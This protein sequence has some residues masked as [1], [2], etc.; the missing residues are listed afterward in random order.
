MDSHSLANDIYPVNQEK[1]TQC[2]T[3]KGVGLVKKETITCETCRN[4]LSCTYCNQ[5]G[6][7]NN[8]YEECTKC[9]GA[10]EV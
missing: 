9:W 1:K 7:S 8:P 6:K 4:I 2:V 10:G 3:C 5:F